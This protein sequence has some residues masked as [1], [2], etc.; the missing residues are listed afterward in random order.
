MKKHFLSTILGLAVLSFVGQA[1]ATI[2]NLDVSNHFGNQIWFNGIGFPF[3]AS[4]SSFSF[5]TS[6]GIGTLESTGS[7]YP[8]Q[9]GW[10][11]TE[12]FS[13][14]SYI[15]SKF[16]FTPTSY[17]NYLSTLV[18]TGVQC[19]NTPGCAVFSGYPTSTAIAFNRMDITIANAT[20]P[21]S[22]TYYYTGD[23]TEMG[24]Y[25]AYIHYNFFNNSTPNLT[26][27]YWFDADANH[28]G[29]PDGKIPAGQGDHYWDLGLPS[30]SNA[31]PEPA[32]MAL[33]GMGLMGLKFRRNKKA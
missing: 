12:V 31:V 15:N 24:M 28:D 17:D 25:D 26:L 7:L 18:Q 5:N 30:G 9:S 6:T 22:P 1:Q 19:Q 32:T 33:M 13:G 16:G 23:G 11:I 8:G 3:M 20:L 2:I 27:A 29:I 14:A 21:G 4:S 10:K